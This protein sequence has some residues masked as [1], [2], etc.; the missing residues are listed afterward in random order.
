MLGDV[1]NNARG[2]I[3]A[4]RSQFNAVAPVPQLQQPQPAMPK[5][6]IPQAQP[7]AKPPMPQIPAMPRPGVM[8][9]GKRI[10]KF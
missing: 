1:R 8:G 2:Q 3:N 10:I 5:M 6:T 9:I 4:M 7:F